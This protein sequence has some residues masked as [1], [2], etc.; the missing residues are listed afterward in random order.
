M[1]LKKPFKDV[2]EKMLAQA[3]LMIL[4]IDGGMSFMEFLIISSIVAATR[5]RRPRSPDR[6]RKY[7]PIDIDRWSEFEVWTMFRFTRAHLYRLYHCF[8]WPEEGFQTTG[9]CPTKSSSFEAFLIVM[10]R[11]ANPGKW[12]STVPYFGPHKRSH[13]SAIFSSAMEH[14]VKQKEHLL[15][16]LPAYY[17]QPA[18]LRR[19]ATAVYRVCG[20]LPNIVAFIDGTCKRIARPTY[21]QRLFYSRY[22]RYHCVK[23]QH[24]L[25]PD[26]IIGHQFG[27]IEGRHSDAWLFNESNICDDILYSRFQFPAGPEHMPPH[28]VPEIPVFNGHVQYAIFGDSG[29]ARVGD[30]L[31]TPFNRFAYMTAPQKAFNKAMSAVRIAIEWSFGKIVNMFAY[32]SFWQQLKIWLVPVGHYYR[33]ATILSNCHTC[34]YGSQTSAHFGLTPPA[35]EEYMSWGPA[36]VA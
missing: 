4:L 3:I 2:H 5:V 26:G 15:T 31:H 24:L 16:T 7:S 18:T 11:M 8:Q 36:H 30:V 29:Y 20:Y 13:L 14:M 33:L 12:A 25:F 19:F 28:D 35:L 32:L 27:P 17:S 22:K 21:F 34:L 23:F 10:F 1:P 6:F 9:D